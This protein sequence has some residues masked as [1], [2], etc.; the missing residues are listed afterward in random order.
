[1]NTHLI[2]TKANDRPYL[3]RNEPGCLVQGIWLLLVGW[4]LGGLAITFAWFLNNTIIGLPLGMLILNQLPRIMA[5][6]SPQMVIWADG[7]VSELPQYPFLLRAIYFLLIG[8]WW[9]GVWLSIS[10]VFSITLI[11]MPVG[12]AMIRKAPFMTT[13][14]K[15]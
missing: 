6:Q 14:K 13:L 10:W 2:S 11:F 5:L 8:W 15:F 1:M 4:W 9:S 3:N 12:L 7:G